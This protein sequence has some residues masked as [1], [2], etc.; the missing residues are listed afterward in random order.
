MEI[1]LYTKAIQ[2]ARQLKQTVGEKNDY[3]ITIAQLEALLQNLTHPTNKE[4]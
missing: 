3:Y 1:E 4:I 2:L